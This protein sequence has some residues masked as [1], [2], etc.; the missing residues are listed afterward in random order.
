MY[1]SDL[2]ENPGDALAVTPLGIIIT[3]M[4]YAHYA[5]LYSSQYSILQSFFRIK[6]LIY[7]AG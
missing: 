6:A 7:A 3:L 4:L 2:I 5:S 1:T